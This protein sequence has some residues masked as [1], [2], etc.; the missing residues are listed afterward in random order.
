MG[1]LRLCSHLIAGFLDLVEVVEVIFHRHTDGVDSV[2]AHQPL[3][4]QQLIQVILLN[5]ETV[6]NRRKEYNHFIPPPRGKRTFTTALQN[7]GE[8]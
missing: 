5:T 6:K 2:R 7:K 8:N 1:P 4:G 3:P